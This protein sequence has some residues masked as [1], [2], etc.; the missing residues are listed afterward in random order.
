[1]GSNIPAAQYSRISSSSTV[2][3][4]VQILNKLLT[5]VVV[6]EGGSEFRC[7]YGRRR[8]LALRQAVRRVLFDRHSA[9]PNRNPCNPK[10]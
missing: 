10:P 3:V 9:K 6:R 5:I 8:W 4:S 7:R 2:S 1:M